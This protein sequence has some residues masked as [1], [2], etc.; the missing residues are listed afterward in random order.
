MGWPVYMPAAWTVYM[1]AERVAQS[2]VAMLANT[3][4]G[5]ITM[6]ITLIALYII[7]NQDYLISHRLTP[8]AHFV[9]TKI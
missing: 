2:T 8:Y 3:L 9:F 5:S 7:T 4:L 1:P 6:P